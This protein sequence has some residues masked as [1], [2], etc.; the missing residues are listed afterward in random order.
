[1]SNK[2][3]INP[4]TLAVAAVG[5]IVVALVAASLMYDSQ[6]AQIVDDGAAARQVALASEQ[7]PTLGDPGAQ[8]HIVEFLDPACETC[9]VF[10]P[11]V[12]TWYFQRDL[13]FLYQ[14]RQVWA[15][16]PVSGRLRRNTHLIQPGSVKIQTGMNR[17]K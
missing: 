2:K 3:S 9:A 15:K 6:R 13:S 14:I 4:T 8:V 1:M 17:T 7:A 10:F 11:M 12:K 5:V 16:E